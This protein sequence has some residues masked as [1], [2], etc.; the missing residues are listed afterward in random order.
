[1]KKILVIIWALFLILLIKPHTV[2]AIGITPDSIRID[3]E[4]NFEN[5]YIFKTEKAENTGIYIEGGLAEYLNI[6]EDNIAKDGSF[7]IRVKL[8]S[9]IE[10]PGDNVV[11][12][13]VLEGAK[14]G[15]MV[16]GRASIRTPIVIKVPYP[17]IYAEISFN[18]ND[19]GINETANF[20]VKINNLGKKDIDKA[21]AVIDILDINERLVEKLFTE[22]K[23]VN[24]KEVQELKAFFNASKHTAGTYKAIAH[25]NYADKSKD[26]E[27]SFR[28]G[29]LNVKIINYTR[30]FFK[31]KIDTFEIEIESGWNKRIDNI[32]AEVKVFNNTKE[33][34]S[35]KTVSFSLEPWE[36]KT[37]SAFW[38]PQ[39][40]GEGSYDV[41]ITLFY[42][43]EK[44]KLSG[45]IDII[46]Q[47]EEFSFFKK[48]VTV[49]NLLIVLVVLLVIIN[50]IILMK[51]SKK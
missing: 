46:V 21:K 24:V 26:L 47:K 23:A 6:E 37:I 22:E 27:A 42:E 35:F 12:V 7:V 5:S 2:S 1:M 11:F 31:N 41:E 16:S 39:G 29:S 19:L 28:I 51:K 36:K 10:M 3:F 25:V 13:G 17:G 44:T 8:P 48:Y 20:I 40:L 33:V 18:V 43:G 15:G 38:D 30:T 34:S 32:F 49:I 14:G 9:E 50:I 45:E 4:P